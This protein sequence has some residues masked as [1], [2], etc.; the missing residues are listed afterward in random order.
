MNNTNTAENMQEPISDVREIDRLYEKGLLGNENRLA[1]RRYSAG[2]CFYSDW[3]HSMFNPDFRSTFGK[4]EI[5]LDKLTA[6]DRYL[7]VY[8]QIPAK[9]RYFV[10]CILIIGESIDEYMLRYPIF[11][12]TADEKAVLLLTLQDALDVIDGAYKTIK[13]ME[14]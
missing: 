5:S 7:K 10:R 2:Q 6:A 8:R 9:W 4:N 11:N 3:Q 13:E 12:R 14:R 1:M